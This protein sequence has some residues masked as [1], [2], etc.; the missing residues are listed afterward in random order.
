MVPSKSEICPN[1]WSASG[2]IDESPPCIPFITDMAGLNVIT[3]SPNSVIVFNRN[4]ICSKA[5]LAELTILF[6]FRICESSLD[7]ILAYWLS[8]FCIAW[9][10]RLK[11]RWSFSSIFD[12]IVSNFE[13]CICNFFCASS[14]LGFK[15]ACGLIPSKNLLL[16]LS[17]CGFIH[18]L[19]NDIWLH[20]SWVNIC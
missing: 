20:A 3:T 15:G 19:P 1:D 13:I 18:L 14:I 2:I 11:I 8:W 4:C 5:N 16:T 9:T 17:P 6:I 12:D 10:T 7:N